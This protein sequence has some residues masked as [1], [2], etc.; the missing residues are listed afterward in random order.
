MDVYRGCQLKRN[1][2]VM[3]RLFR[4]FTHERFRGVRSV[5]RSMLIAK[6]WF[7]LVWDRI[8]LRR[9]AE[10]LDCKFTPW[11]IILRAPSVWTI[12]PG[13]SGMKNYLELRT[14]SM[15]IN[16]TVIRGWRSLLQVWGLPCLARSVAN[17][18]TFIDRTIR[19]IAASASMAYVYSQE[20]TPAATI[21]TSPDSLSTEDPLC[22]I[23]IMVD[24]NCPLH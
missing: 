23:A 10:L 5:P 20:I 21:C 17:R 24:S 8:S 11:G 18:R 4:Y 7:A 2:I 19:V 22:P 3:W 1:F 9:H 13:G 12:S 15:N 16:L 6:K 14:T